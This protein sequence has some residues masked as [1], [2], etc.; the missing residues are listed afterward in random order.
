M[1]KRIGC[2]FIS[3]TLAIF[4][5]QPK[6]SESFVH[7]SVTKMLSG[8]SSNDVKLINSSLL[9]LLKAQSIMAKALGLKEQA[10]LAKITAK[11]LELGD[12]GSEEGMEKNIDKSI[13][14]QK[15]IG[16]AMAKNVVLDVKSKALFATSLLP[17]GSGT[18]QMIIAT[19]NAIET[20][21]KVAKGDYMSG[22]KQ[23]GTFIVLAKKGP[24][25]LSTFSKA[26]E[27]IIK[28]AQNNGIPTDDL[29]EK[30]DKLWST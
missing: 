27:N 29:K 7:T 24:S 6:I 23:S 9:K 3:W 14:I 19:R 12:L 15:E 30:M 8:S 17:Y 28:F 5:I 11:G 1:K 20:G 22:L 16:L 13:E 4:V 18:F 2:I 26:T 25:I 10:E 21:K